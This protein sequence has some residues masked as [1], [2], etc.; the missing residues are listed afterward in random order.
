M[1]Y[2][3][4]FGFGIYEAKNDLDRILRRISLE[5][6]NNF[7]DFVMRNFTEYYYRLKREN[8]EFDKEQLK[9]D[10]NLGLKTQEE[11]LKALKEIEK[12]EKNLDDEVKR[13]LDQNLKLDFDYPDYPALLTYSVEQITR[14]GWLIIWERLIFENGKIKNKKIMYYGKNF[15]CYDRDAPLIRLWNSIIEEYFKLLSKY[16]V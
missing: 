15:N 11:Y 13:Y 10:L 12:R 14:T 1:V 9:I 4:S 5:E 8:I 7:R 2:K 16:D 6:I 3:I